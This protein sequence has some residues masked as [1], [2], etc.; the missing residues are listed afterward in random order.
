VEERFYRELEF[1]TAG[2]RGVLGAGTY[3]MN[4]YVVRARRRACANFCSARGAKER[5]VC[6]AYDS[7]L[8]SAEFAK[9][10]PGARGKRQQGVSVFHAAFR[11]L[12]SFAVRHLTAWR[13]GDHRSHNRQI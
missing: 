8:F 5:G 2:L 13:R 11:A 1:G 7:R 6:I 3:R 12:L 4:V 10:P 9:R